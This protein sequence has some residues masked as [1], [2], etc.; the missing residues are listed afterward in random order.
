MKH[1]LRLLLL[2]GAALVSMPAM[3]QDRLEEGFPNSPQQALPRIYVDSRVIPCRAP[4]YFAGAPL[5]PS[6]LMGPVTLIE[7]R[8][9]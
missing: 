8:D 6:G 3:S 2:A 1:P 7:I 5:L 4:A 9:R